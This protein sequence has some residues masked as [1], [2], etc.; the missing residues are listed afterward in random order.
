MARIVLTGCA[1]F[2]GSH[3]ARR[4]LRDGHAV[5]GLDSLNDYYDPA[6]KR[7]RLALL[8]P[9]RAFQFT[10]ADVADR[11]ALAA[12]LDG[13]A[14][15]YVIHLAA[16]VG[17]RNSVKNPRA[18][19][20]AN[21]DGF[22]NVLDGCARR[23]VRHLV[24]ASSSSVYGANEKVPFSEDRSGRSPISYYAAT[25]KANEVMAHAYAHLV[26]AARHRAALL[27]RVRPVG[28]PGHGADPV[29]A[30]H[31]ARASPSRSS[32][33]AGCAATSPTSTTWSSRSSGWWSGRPRRRAPPR[34]TAS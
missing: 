12:V 6:L 34:R 8:A 22:F 32:T 21:L 26:P 3:V 33:T 28:P 27:H 7:A 14:P 30:G 1:G 23:G 17:V 2:I 20:E 10:H 13:A 4:L 29:R 25:K 16:Q 18:Y 9:E 24:Y 19:T 31:P 5:S 11:H 15:E